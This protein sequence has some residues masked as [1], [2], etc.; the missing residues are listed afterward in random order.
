MQLSRARSI[1]Q[2][3]IVGVRHS[4]FSSQTVTYDFKDLIID[5]ETKG[6]PL[7]DLHLLEE[8]QMPMKATT[9][10]DELMMY[11]KNMIKMRRTE[12][13]ADRLY[14]GKMIRGFCH[15]YDGQES[16]AEG[17]EAGLTRDDAIITAYRDHC[18]ALAR[19]DTPYRVIAEMVQK[20]TGSS[21]GKG[22]S[23]HY[24]NSKAN[25]YGGNGIVGAQCPVGVGLA[26]ALKYQGKPNIAVNMYGDGAAN[27]GQ[28][29]EAANMAALWKLPAVFMCENNLYGM[30]TSNARAAAN[31]KYYA[32][33]DT[34]PGFKIDA[35]NVLIVRETM[36]WT[37]QYCVENGPMFIEYL[38]YRYH[39]HSMSDPGI[40]YRTRDEI[41]HVRDYRD[42][43]GLV[44]HMLIEN[45]WAT[46]KE[47]KAIEKEIRASIEA[48]VV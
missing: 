34:I 46:E 25:F 12:L 18:Q 38:T 30:G 44:K 29:Y 1:L 4:L 36:K 9:S 35:Q 19:G 20:K 14:K 39:G 7:Y 40:T 43:I 33:G 31:T 8:S 24:Y 6:K 47:L 3:G 37:K 13:E 45:S 41:K 42:P 26:F 17:M 10:K 2:S 5:P 16:I 48:D 15:L 28:L 21:G 23:M 22:G 32:R 11:L 27:Q